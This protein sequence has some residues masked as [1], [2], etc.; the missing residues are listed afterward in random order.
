MATSGFNGVSF[1]FRVTSQ[2]GIAISTT[3]KY[4]SAHIEESIKQILT[5]HPL[6]R[7]MEDGFSSKV[8]TSLFEPNNETLKTVIKRQ[9]VEA[10]RVLDKRVE[11]KESGIELTV[12]TEND[13]SE[14]LYATV[15][16]KVIKYQTYYETTVNLG[17][18]K[19][20]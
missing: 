10:I 11:L 18:I 6:E 9:I 19:N 3:N 16:Y 8:I 12:V 15:T 20:E 7:P 17:E 14:F 13:G 1:P 4:D 5:T 2:G